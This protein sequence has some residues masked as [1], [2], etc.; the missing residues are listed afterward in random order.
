MTF[1]EFLDR[2]YKPEPGAAVSLASIT[3]LFYESYSL[4]SFDFPPNAIRRYLESRFPV[5]SLDHETHVGN[6][7]GPG[8]QI[9]SDLPLVAA[10]GQL[11]P[12]DLQPDE[13]PH[14]AGES[15][16]R[17]TTLSRNQMSARGWGKIHFSRA[18]IMASMKPKE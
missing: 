3:Q 11:M 8:S 12:R 16:P 17:I 1:A 10:F 14:R 13:F 6:L 4:A 15:N 9:V 7:T 2:R 18:E 5:A